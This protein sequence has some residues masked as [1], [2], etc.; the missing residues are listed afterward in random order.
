MNWKFTRPGTVTFEKG[1]PFCFITMFPSVAIEDIQPVI[2]PISSDPDFHKEVKIWASER[3]RFNAGLAMRDPY[4]LE[5][6]WQRD[7]LKGESPTG[8]SKADEDHRTK[9]NLKKPI[10]NTP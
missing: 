8:K 10:I 5:Q 9:R 3:V 6:K 7:Y 2:E 1:E 4:T